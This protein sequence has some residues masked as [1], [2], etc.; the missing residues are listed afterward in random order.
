METTLISNKTNTSFR[1][2]LKPTIQQQ[3][4]LTY[5]NIQQQKYKQQQLIAEGIIR[6][7]NLI[8]GFTTKQW[9]EFQN[10]ISIEDYAKK[11]GI[12]I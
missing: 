10:A 8:D 1:T 7:P 9:I 4:V 2:V 11:R 12:A 3:E 6:K 5:K